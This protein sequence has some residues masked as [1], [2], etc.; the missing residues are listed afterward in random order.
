MSRIE[1]HLESRAEQTIWV[2][3]LAHAFHFSLGE[4]IHTEN[5]YKFSPETISSLLRESGLKLE[6]TWTDAHGW[7]SEVLARVL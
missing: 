5:S 6:R 2:R 4:R 3:D 1:M 7:F